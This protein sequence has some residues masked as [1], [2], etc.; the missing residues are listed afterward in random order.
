VSPEEVVDGVI[1]LVSLPEV[2]IKVNEMVDDP[3][4]SANDIG[5][6][7]M[8]DPSLS[9]RL[10]RIVN[11]SYYGFASKITTI[12]RAVSVIGTQDLRNLILA[13]SA[14]NAFSSIPNE[15]VNMETHWRHSVYTGV[16][17]KI[18]AK[19]CHVLH[20]ERLFIG[21]L[22]HDIGKL[23]LYH[24]LAKE[25]RD[26]LLIA[27]GHPE[28]VH[29]IEQDVLGFTHADVGFEL[30]KCWNLPESLQEV[31]KYH[32]N[33]NPSSEYFMDESI[34]HIANVYSLKLDQDIALDECA[35]LVDPAAWKNIAVSMDDMED[36]VLLAEPEF[37]NALKMILQDSL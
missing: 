24:R 26:I 20:S 27:D 12:T 13:T 23:V 28:A 7:I 21:G 4:T 29:D 30:S 25:A 36:V 37:D 22:L 18:I 33:P 3:V 15:L 5:N 35:A 9:A 19:K 17:A 16:L 31:I 32:H 2:C 1:N 6:V 34:V 10:L 8:G 11:S 14:V